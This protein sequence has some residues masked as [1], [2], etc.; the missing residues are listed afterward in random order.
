MYRFSVLKNEHEHP[1]YTAL[2]S[3]AP[4]TFIFTFTCCTFAFSALMPLLGGRQKE[5]LACKKLRDE[6]LA[7][8]SVWHE[9]K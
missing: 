2:R 1:A 7:W 8:L 3:M 5:H 9:R 4:F 6:V